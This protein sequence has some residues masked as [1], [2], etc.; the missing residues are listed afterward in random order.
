MADR[1]GLIPFVLRE[2]K[3]GRDVPY[4]P[5][6][7]AGQVLM[8]DG[9]PLADYLAAS[10]PDWPLVT[11]RHDLGDYPDVLLL[12]GE[13][14]A[15]AGGAGDG[16]AGGSE[17]VQCPCRQSYPDADTLTVYTIRELTRL[18]IPTLHK[19]SDRI[20]TLTFENAES[21]YIKLLLNV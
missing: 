10:V 3:D 5:L 8:P 19:I 15:G 18:G 13:Y 2:R 9:V 4:A 21:L 6:T 11:I 1:T 12:M 14:T 16:P 20:Y 17:L 7:T